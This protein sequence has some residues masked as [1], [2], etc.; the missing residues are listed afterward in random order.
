MYSFL[1]S[2]IIYNDRASGLRQVC[3]R[4]VQ[5]NLSK[6]AR[7]QG[8]ERS[9]CVRFASGLRSGCVRVAFGLNSAF[10]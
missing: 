7:V 1:Y 9:V 8:S 6:A 5:R 10:Y 3:V 2:Y 4:V